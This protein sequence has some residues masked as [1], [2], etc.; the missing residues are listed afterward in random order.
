MAFGYRKEGE[1]V[2]FGEETGG[3]RKVQCYKLSK[4]FPN[5]YQI[6]RYQRQGGYLTDTLVLE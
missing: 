1:D 6:I 5:Q 3:A 4:M 2:G